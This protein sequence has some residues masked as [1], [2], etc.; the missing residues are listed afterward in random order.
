MISEYT[1]LKT[2]N[3]SLVR[4][5]AVTLQRMDG[6]GQFAVLGEPLPVSLDLVSARARI[7][8][9]ECINVYIR[10][11]IFFIIF[12]M[13]LRI[14]CCETAPSCTSEAT[15]SP[16]T[17]TSIPVGL[18][19]SARPSLCDAS[20]TGGRSFCTDGI[21]KRPIQWFGE[22]ILISRSTRFFIFSFLGGFG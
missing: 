6:D 17:L 3:I 11:Q 7:W 13:Q 15:L 18:R 10:K 19:M 5:K 21:C 20:M 16:V 2:R 9:C 12:L 14:L 4:F 1:N 8:K 22:R